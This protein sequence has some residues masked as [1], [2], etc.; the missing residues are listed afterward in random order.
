MNPTDPTQPAVDPTAVPVDPN[1]GVQTPPPAM[2]EEPVAPQTPEP[3]EVPMGE[4]PASDISGGDQ[5][6]SLPP[7]TP[8]T[9]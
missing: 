1:A 7:T 2:P 9:V 3:V 4:Q 5:G 8:P 6:G